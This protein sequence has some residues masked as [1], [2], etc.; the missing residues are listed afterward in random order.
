[1]GKGVAQLFETIVTLARSKSC[2][3][4]QAPSPHLVE[5]LQP[6]AALIDRAKYLSY[7]LYKKVQRRLAP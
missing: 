1:M 7:A 4:P 2:P 6:L 5:S 3:L